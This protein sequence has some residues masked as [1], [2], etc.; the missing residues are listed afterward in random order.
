LHLVP[1]P[2]PIHPIHPGPLMLQG[3]RRVGAA[4]LRAAMP[5][6][7]V[8]APLLPWP[9]LQHAS[10]SVPLLA[11]RSSSLSRCLVVSWP[12]HAHFGATAT[13]QQQQA[14]PLSAPFYSLPSLSQ[15]R[16]R[17]DR[18][19]RWQ[20]P[21]GRQVLF[22]EEDVRETFVRGGGHGG[23]SVAKTSNCVQLLHVP[24]GIS[25]RCHATRSRDLNRKLARRELQMRLDELA[26]GRESYRSKKEAKKKRNA[27]KKRARSKEKYAKVEGKGGK[28][29]EEALPPPE[30][31]AGRPDPPPVFLALVWGLGGWGRVRAGVGVGVGVG[32]AGRGRAAAGARVWTIGSSPASGSGL[33]FAGPMSK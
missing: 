10:R 29:E 20:S 1:R 19:V 15:V 14:S 33:A 11:P 9:A 27:A 6:R 7:V 28:E 5:A 18:S 23:Q 3:P 8:D 26:N 13:P 2:D 17:H 21:G 12:G 25:V 22:R 4:A 30:G 24:T 31:V 16:H 32:G